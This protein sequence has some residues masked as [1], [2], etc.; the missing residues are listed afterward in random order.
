MKTLARNQEELIKEI[1]DAFS[2]DVSSDAKYTIYTI[3]NLIESNS[4]V[5]ESIDELHISI[6]NSNKQNE[7][8]QKRIFYLTIVTVFLTLVQVFAVLVELL[9]K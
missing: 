7:I 6:S 9:K 1:N 8:L 5:E 4:R 2:R 3:R